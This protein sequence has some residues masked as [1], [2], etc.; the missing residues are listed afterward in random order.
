VSVFLGGPS[1]SGCPLSRTNAHTPTTSQ[2]SHEHTW[3]PTYIRLR[4]IELWPELNV[5][6]KLRKTQEEANIA[7]AEIE[8]KKEREKKASEDKMELVTFTNP[9][10][11]PEP[12]IL[13]PAHLR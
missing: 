2:H 4:K 3:V 10:S 5:A 7:R 13:N 11:H 1:L 6:G 8:E 9:N 12:L